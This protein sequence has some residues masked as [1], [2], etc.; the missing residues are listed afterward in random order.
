MV[1]RTRRVVPRRHVLAGA[2]L[3][4]GH[5]AVCERSRGDERKLSCGGGFIGSVDLGAVR[6][7]DGDHRQADRDAECHGMNHCIDEKDEKLKRFAF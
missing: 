3:G 4:A 1:R 2:A 7:S 6:T 5:A